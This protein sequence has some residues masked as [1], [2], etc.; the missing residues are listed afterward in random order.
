MSK[1]R[2]KVSPVEQPPTLE[3]QLKL[4]RAQCAYLHR[5]LATAI[6][7]GPMAPVDVA[8]EE[9]LRLENA[10][11]RKDLGTLRLHYAQAQQDI[12][13]LKHSL[14]FAHRALGWHPDPSWMLSDDQYLD[15]LLL[16]LLT[17][18]HPDRWSQGQA[19]VDLAHELTV[20]INDARARLVR[21][22]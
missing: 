2:T 13:Q 11:L 14:A 22:E 20:A 16:Q 10:N 7:H 1:S 9:H 5:E 8:S 3:E 17:L 18:A 21:K 4:S 19:A 15:S 12:A 6:K